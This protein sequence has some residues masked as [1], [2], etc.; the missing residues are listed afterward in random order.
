[1]ATKPIPAPYI[2]RVQYIPLLEALVY[3]HWGEK[4]VTGG[5][6][7]SGELTPATTGLL[8]GVEID[9][10]DRE[11]EVADVGK[12]AD[13]EVVAMDGR[14]YHEGALLPEQCEHVAMDADDGLG[15]LVFHDLTPWGHIAKQK[16]K[17][18]V[19][20]FV[21]VCVNSP[22]FKHIFIVKVHP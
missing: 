13:T 8:L 6:M 4:R 3:T 2:E 12:V 1:M 22:H 5:D 20:V 21:C 16:P 14:H 18:C 15:R 10:G 7:W 9:C 19:C 11:A 17:V